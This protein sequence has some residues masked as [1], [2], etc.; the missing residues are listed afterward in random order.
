MSHDLRLHHELLLLALHD[1]KGTRAF[2]SWLEIG[3]A[4]AVLSELLLEERVELRPEGRKGKELVTVVSRAVIGDDVLDAGL[5]RLIEAKRRADARSTVSRLSRIK[6]L[7]TR[8]ALTLCRRGVLR[9][10][11]DRVLL[12]FRRRVYPTLD[13]A[14][15]A[16]LVARVR[17][18][19]EAPGSEVADRTA[20][21]V[22]LANAT[23]TLRSIYSARE[24]RG[25]KARLAE[26]KELGGAG[27]RAAHKAVE[28][29][30]A[31]LVATMAAT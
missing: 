3:L 15:E 9:E 19:I 28:A 7:R 24:L 31:A 20:I 21:L 6:E 25:H 22:T 4:G 2:G 16:A 17:E 30:T 26:L 14:P 27:G 23:Q 5:R 18:A 11:E 13:P 1:D 29:A 10:E 12:L 8:T